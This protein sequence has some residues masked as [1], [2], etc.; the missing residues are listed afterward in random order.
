MKTFIKALTAAGIATMCLSIG[1]TS[2]HAARPTEAR[3]PPGINVHARLCT[4]H[5]IVDGIDQG[6]GCIN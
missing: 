3:T 2:A 1:T 5:L 6:P 4:G